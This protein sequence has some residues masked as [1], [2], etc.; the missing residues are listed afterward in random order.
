MAGVDD[1]GDD[2]ERGEEDAEDREGVREE[3]KGELRE[4]K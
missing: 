3:K 1:G 4:Y 2:D